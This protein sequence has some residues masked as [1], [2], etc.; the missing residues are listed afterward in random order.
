M[1]LTELCYAINY[2]SVINVW[3]HGFVPRE[4]FMQHLE[5]RFNKSVRGGEGHGGAGGRDGEGR[6]GTGRDGEG[7]GGMGNEG[8]KKRKQKLRLQNLR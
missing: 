2:C 1:A 8:I 3:E 7:W 4:F 6:G 5:A